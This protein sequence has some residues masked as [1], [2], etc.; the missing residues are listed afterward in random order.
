VNFILLRADGVIAVSKRNM[1]SQKKDVLVLDMKP[2]EPGAF[3]LSHGDQAPKN[4]N[5]LEA[6][7]AINIQDNPETRYPTP[8]E[9]V[10]IQNETSSTN[11]RRPRLFAHKIRKALRRANKV[12]RK[13][14]TV[15]QRTDGQIE[16]GGLKEEE[17]LIQK[18]LED[19]VPAEAIWDRMLE[20][21]VTN[22]ALLRQV[23]IAGFATT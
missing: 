6:S 5:N 16:E 7:A 8:V 22:D 9:A 13:N 4:T 2:R 23:T 18:M 20:L 3:L 1:C 17:Q 19:N 10:A 12:G 15:I 14:D 21:E 11:R